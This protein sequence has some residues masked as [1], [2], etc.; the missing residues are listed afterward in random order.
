VGY[1]NNSTT[2]LLTFAH[3]T[4]RIMYTVP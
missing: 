4:L 2:D 3:P 1:S